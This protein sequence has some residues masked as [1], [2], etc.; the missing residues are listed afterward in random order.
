MWCLCGCWLCGCGCGLWLW[1]WLWLCGCVAVWQ[2][3]CGYVAVAVALCVV[4]AFVSRGGNCSPTIG[5]HSYSVVLGAVEAAINQHPAIATSAVVTMGAEGEDKRLVACIVP[6]AWAA[7]GAETGP[8]PAA[9]ELHEFLRP[10]LPYY[11]IPPTII[12]LVAL[13]I[14]AASSKLDRKGVVALINERSGVQDRTA[15]DSAPGAGTLNC[16]GC[17]GCCGCGC[18]CV[19][20]FIGTNLTHTCGCA[21][22]ALCMALSQQ[23]LRLQ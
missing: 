23:H 8:A 16:N 21:C 19:A 11:A 15:R 2:C 13:P 10:L 20:V 4:H 7:A 17:C 5:V 9:D 6:E 3:C 1:L 22:M 14:H 18:G 12:P